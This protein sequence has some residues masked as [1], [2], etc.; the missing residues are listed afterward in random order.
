MSGHLDG[1][2]KLLR[3]PSLQ[4]RTLNVGGGSCLEHLIEVDAKDVA[5]NPALVPME[6]I[7]SNSTKTV[8]RYHSPEIL[9]TQES[10]ILARDRVN[11]AAKQAWQEFLLEQVKPKMMV[12]LQDA[13]KGL[14]VIDCLL[15]LAKLACRPGYVCPEFP[16]E[17]SEGLVTINLKSARHPV[18]ERLLEQSGSDAVFQP[19]DILLRCQGASRSCLV[20]TG[21]NM[22][23]KSTY[24]KMASILCLMGQVG[25]FVPAEQAKLPILDN[26][27]TRM[28]AG[29]DL[30]SGRS[31]FATELY[32]RV[33]S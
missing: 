31:T 32:Q 19:N 18:A 10:L 28:G 33:T 1:I 17:T 23:G 25:S 20:V 5:S 22:G 3:K 26:I 2:R 24:V 4:Y 7:Q 8:L 14:S 11:I 21:P 9:K 30:A 15:S 16:T 29:D 12:P 6:W 13:I 27:F